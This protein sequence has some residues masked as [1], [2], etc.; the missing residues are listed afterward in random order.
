[1]N[2]QDPKNKKFT[3]NVQKNPKLKNII[4]G[5]KKSKVEGDNPQ[6]IQPQN[7]ENQQP[8]PQIDIL[9]L[10]KQLNDLKEKN[11]R[12]VALIQNLQK[13]TADDIARAKRRA[14]FDFAKDVLEIYENMLL[15]VQSIDDK[16]QELGLIDNQNNGDS[17][18]IANNLEENDLKNIDDKTQK[19][20]NQESQNNNMDTH[21]EMLLSIKKG[22]DMSMSSF[23][24]K[25]KKYKIQRIGQVGEKFDYHRHQALQNI[26]SDEVE[27]DHIVQ[28][29]RAGYIMEG[30]VIVPALVIVAQ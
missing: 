19:I 11:L 14:N 24:Q 30:E 29:L 20:D 12:H 23:T 21:H 5:L 17:E 6:K 18:E 4:D 10:Q 7:A 25:I 8:E 13:K 3:D 22:I 28:V 9:N 26:A 15:A 16:L 1:M 27:S 2:E